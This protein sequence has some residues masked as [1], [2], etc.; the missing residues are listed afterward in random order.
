MGKHV[1]AET[2]QSEYFRG[3]NEERRENHTRIDTNQLPLHRSHMTDSNRGER[4][5][6]DSFSANTRIAFASRRDT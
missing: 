1:R 2:K 4:K 6:G 3:M 5:S